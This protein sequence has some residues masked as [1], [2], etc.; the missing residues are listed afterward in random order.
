MADSLADTREQLALAN[1]ILAREGIVDAFGHVSMRHPNDPTRFLMSRH[2]APEL[3]KPED[4]LEYHLDTEPVH[5]TNLRHYGERVIHGCIYQARP[6]VMAVCH[7]HAPAILAYAIAR[8]PLTPVYHLGAG[9]GVTVPLWDSRDDFGDTALVVVKPEEGRSLAKALGPNWTIMMGRHGAT[10]AGTSLRE[11]VFRTVFGEKNAQLQTQA[12]LLG[13]V[14]RLTPKE[15]EL[16]AAYNLRP[17]PVERAWDLFVKRVADAEAITR[18]A[19]ASRA[20]PAAKPTKPAAKSTKASK[21]VKAVA[22]KTAKKSARNKAGKAK[23][24]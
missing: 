9:L 12:Q 7:H 21:L 8:K 14:D 19:P 2:R 16:A 23:R 10:V 15:I 3:V 20:R 22:S 11:L 18:P 13:H 24:K 1:R 5:P 4:I 6:D 17:G